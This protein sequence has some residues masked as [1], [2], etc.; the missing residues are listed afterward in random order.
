[1]CMYFEF[2]IISVLLTN[3][4]AHMIT[5]TH[6][7]IY[8]QGLYSNKMVAIYMRTFCMIYISIV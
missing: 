5:L 7:A 4:F 3:S 2:N 8:I 1:M 6:Y